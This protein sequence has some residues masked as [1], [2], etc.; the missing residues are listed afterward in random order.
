[1]GCGYISDVSSG[2]DATGAKRSRACPGRDRRPHAA[3]SPRRQAHRALVPQGPAPARQ[4]R[5]AGGSRR[6]YHIPMRL[7]HRP[8]VRQLL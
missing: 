5:T 2:S 3:A 4:P 1:M 8:M 7:H 6:C